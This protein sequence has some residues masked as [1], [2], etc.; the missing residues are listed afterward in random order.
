MAVFALGVGIVLLAFVFSQDLKVVDSRR[1]KLIDVQW[2]GEYQSNVRELRLTEVATGR[3]LWG[4]KAAAGRSFPLWQIP[5]EVGQ[6]GV[7]PD[8]TTGAE[9]VTPRAPTFTL[10]P[11]T[12]YRVDLWTYKEGLPRH[13]STNFA[14]AKRQGA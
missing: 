14:L 10:V 3:V 7:I 12:A 1:G 5:L 13:V 9:V 8:G 6:N 11:D 2:L 4:L